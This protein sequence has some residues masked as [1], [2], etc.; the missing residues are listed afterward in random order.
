M[1]YRGSH[2]RAEIASCYWRD[3]ELNE[4]RTIL[5][6]A[7]GKL[8]TEG[9]TRA[10]TLLK[11]TTVEHTATRY[12]EALRILNDNAALFQKLRHHTTRGSYHSELAIILWSLATSE[13]NKDYLRQAVKEYEQADRQF[14]LARNVVYRADVKNNVGFLLL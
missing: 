3:G 10:R 12:H 5:H 9:N 13:K 8:T 11:L 2:L 7:L 1:T 6:E 4:A 14:K